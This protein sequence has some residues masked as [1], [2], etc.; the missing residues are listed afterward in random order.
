MTVAT[1]TAVVG[2]HRTKNHLY[3][4]SG[5]GPWPGVTTI[6]KVLDA[7]ALTSWKLNQVATAAV[8]NA[9]RLIEDR[10]SGKTDAAVKWLTTLSSTA[11]DRGHRIHATLESV[12]RR[13]P[14]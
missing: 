6:T 11:M 12:L 9:E 14:V 3:Y 4:F 5:Q 1:R 2:P 7:P 8:E 10:E 13:E